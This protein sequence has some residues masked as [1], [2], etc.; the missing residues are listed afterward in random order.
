MCYSAA[1]ALSEERRVVL[2]RRR[3]ECESEKVSEGVAVATAGLKSAVQA[4]MRVHFQLYTSHFR[5][6]VPRGVFSTTCIIDS[7]SKACRSPFYNDGSQDVEFMI[8]KGDG[9]APLGSR[10]EMPKRG[11]C[12]PQE[13]S[14]GNSLSS[15]N[16]LALF[17]HITMLAQQFCA[18]PCLPESLRSLVHAKTGDGSV[19]STA[20]DSSPGRATSKMI[21]RAANWTFIFSVLPVLDVLLH[22]SRSSSK[23]VEARVYSG[24][25]ESSLHSFRCLLL[26]SR[27][28]NAITAS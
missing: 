16:F 1:S 25:T 20:Q 10:A 7:C 23:V 13:T 24:Q 22:S 27:V 17:S 26:L 3:E 5:D 19:Y 15:I 18:S 6:D 28:R 11:T 4:S 12:F 21:E 14:S 9:L 8:H 2:R